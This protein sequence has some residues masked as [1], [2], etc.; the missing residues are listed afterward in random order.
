MPG[1]I[2]KTDGKTGEKDAADAKEKAYLGYGTRV[3]LI[4]RNPSEALDL[5]QEFAP[6]CTD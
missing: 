5:A 6:Y 1:P 2:D 3:Y 4:A